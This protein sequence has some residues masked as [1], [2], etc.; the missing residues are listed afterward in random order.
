MTDTPTDPAALAR[1]AKLRDVLE[2]T[3]IAMH[4]GAEHENV[5]YRRLCADVRKTIRAALEPR[6]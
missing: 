1:E 2:A 4:I 5:S 6:S 3:G